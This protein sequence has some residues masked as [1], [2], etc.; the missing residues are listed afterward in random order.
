M[1][2][3]HF[4][5]GSVL[6]LAVACASAPEAPRPII[7]GDPTPAPPR[8]LVSD[9]D[10]ANA[11]SIDAL[12]GAPALTRREGSGE[13]RRYALTRC[14]LILI[15]YPDE[16]GAQKVAHMEA[17]ASTSSAEKPDLEAC[18]AAG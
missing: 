11:A 10:N 14:T 16:T 5:T 7:A 17:T 15:L 1:R 18:L 3:K 6:L 12:L 2:W 13:Y 8:Y 9:L 4:L